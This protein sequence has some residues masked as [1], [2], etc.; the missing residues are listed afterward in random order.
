MDAFLLDIRMYAKIFGVYENIFVPL[1]RAQ[2]QFSIFRSHN[3]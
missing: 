3:P 1:H 2:S